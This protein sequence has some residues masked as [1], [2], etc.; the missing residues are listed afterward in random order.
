MLSVIVN[1]EI[2]GAQE[3]YLAAPAPLLMTDLDPSSPRMRWLDVV[4]QA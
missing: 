4:S 2:R 3:K 1:L